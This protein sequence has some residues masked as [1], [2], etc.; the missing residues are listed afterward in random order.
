M[1]ESHDL[2]SIRTEL[3]KRIRRIAWR[4]RLVRLVELVSRCLFYCL[5]LAALAILVEKLTSLQISPIHFLVGAV[6]VSF[7]VALISYFVSPISL[8]AAAVSADH[9]LR[10]KEKL[11][12]ALEMIFDTQSQDNEIIHKWQEALVRDA[13]RAA[14]NVSPSRTFPFRLGR[15]GRYMWIPLVVALVFAFLVPEWSGWNTSKAEAAV[16]RQREVAQE[17]N[18]LREKQIDLARRDRP[19]DPSAETEEI[20]QEM[21]KLSRDLVA[22]KLDRREAMSELAKLSEKIE[23]RLATLDKK[24]QEMQPLNQALET[25]L[26]EELANAMMQGDFELVLT[27]LDELEKKISQEN[28]SE[29][30]RKKLGL[31]LEALSK[32]LGEN[33]ELAKALKKAGLAL[34]G[35]NPESVLAALGE[36]GMCASDLKALAEQI[37]ILGKCKGGVCACRANLAGATA[38]CLCGGAGCSMCSGGMGGGMRTDGQGRGG[39][40]PFKETATGFQ[41]DQIQGNMQEAPPIGSFFVKGLPPKGEASTK[42]TDVVVRSRQTA[43]EALNRE[44]VPPTYRSSVRRYFDTLQP[45]PE[46]SK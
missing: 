42:F 5:C 24:Q 27:E 10:L 44:Q 46:A 31:D 38:C 22:G 21:E 25:A 3:V 29:A 13:G 32:S 7:P 8:F 35:K 43:E 41:P 23:Q 11:S 15:E 36:A 37:E 26:A 9:R 4:L 16:E 1:T 30:D 34:K 19:E 17:L 28:L 18:K 2:E 12:T 14:Q 45:Q 33:S 40:A 39:V 20:R 6:V